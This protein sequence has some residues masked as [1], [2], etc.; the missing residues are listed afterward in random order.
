ME[1]ISGLGLVKGNMLGAEKLECN[2]RNMPI[3]VGT[4]ARKEVIQND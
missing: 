2:R 1:T 3:V 4:I